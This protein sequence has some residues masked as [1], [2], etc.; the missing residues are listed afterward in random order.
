MKRL[1]LIPVVLVAWAACKKENPVT[2]PPEHA[3]EKVF[4]LNE[5]NFNWGNASLGWYDLAEK[6]YEADV[7]RR[8]NN[9]ALGDVFQSMTRIGAHYF[10]VVNNSGM[11]WVLDTADLRIQAKIEGLRSP[12][13]MA[14]VTQYVAYITDLYAREI[15]VINLHNFSVQGKIPLPGWTEQLISTHYGVFVVNY[16]SQ[17]LYRISPDTH[18]VNDSLKVGLY[19]MEIKQMDSKT[20]IMLSE[21]SPGR[22]VPGFLA[23]IDLEKFLVMEKWEIPW[24]NGLPRA[25]L[26]D[27]VAQRAYFLING[28]RYLD[29]ALNPAS[30]GSF[31]TK[32]GNL[33]GLGRHPRTGQLWVSDAKNFID[34]SMVY[35]LK[36]DGSDSMSFKA[37]SIASGFWFP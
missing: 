6:K 4:I 34:P 16:H 21:G 15:S 7:F 35:V 33:Y 18:Q 32:S 29:L 13:Y 3:S 8:L 26:M 31:G 12:R 28:I 1:F 19:G 36:A 9:L 37:E 5:G 20:A 14:E 30:F 17:S 25:L 27:T 2:P 11:V 22:G 10:L 24:T 23:M